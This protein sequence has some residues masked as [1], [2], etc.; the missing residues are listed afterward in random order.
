MPPVSEKQR[1]AMH[2]AAHGKST[3]GIPSSVGREFAESDPGGKLPAAKDLAPR[4]WSLLRRLFGEWIDEEQGEPEHAGDAETVHD[5]K[6]GQFTSGSGSKSSE[7]SSE[8]FSSTNHGTNKEKAVSHVKF[9]RTLNH[10]N[11]KATKNTKGEYVVAH[12]FPP[13][14]EAEINKRSRFDPDGGSNDPSRHVNQLRNRRITGD[15][16]PTLATAPNS[17]LPAG[18]TTKTPKGRAASILFA[19]PG[20]KALFLRRSADEENYPDTWALPGGKADEDEEFG[21]CAARE[22]GEETGR[23]CAADMLHEVDRKRTPYGWDHVTFISPVDEEFEPTLNNEHSEHVWSPWDDPPT[24]LHPGV[25]QTLASLAERRAAEEDGA[26]DMN[27]KRVQGGTEPTVSLTELLPLGTKQL[28]SPESPSQGKDMAPA[29]WSML[30]RLFGEWLAE[31]E[32]EPEHAAEDVDLKRDEAGKFATS[33]SGGNS[34]KGEQ[35]NSRREHQESQVL[36]G[37]MAKFHHGRG[38]HEHAAAH[39]YASETHGKAAEVNRWGNKSGE[40]TVSSSQAARESSIHANHKSGY[41]EG[42][43]LGRD[44]IPADCN[45]AHDSVYR[46]KSCAADGTWAYDADLL[47]ATARRARL[48]GRS[49]IA[50][51]AEAIAA[52]EFGAADMAMDWRGTAFL[53]DSSETAADALVSLAFDRESTRTYDPDGRLHVQ[54]AHIS[55]ANVCSYLGREIPDYEQLGLDPDKKYMLYRDPEELSAATDTFNNLPILSEHKP[56]SADE[57][58]HDLVIGSTGTDA[59]FDGTHLDNSLAF[60]PRDAIDDIESNNK[61]QLS[62]AYRYR[63]DMTPGA[64]DSGEKYDGVMRDIVGNHVALV[65]EGRAGPDVVVGDEANPGLD[66]HRGG[67]TMKLRMTPRGLVTAGAIGAYLRPRLAADSRIPVGRLVRDLT[68]QNFKARMPSVAAAIRAA[69]KGRLAADADL[70]D[71]DEFLDAIQGEKLEEDAAPE[72]V[73]TNTGATGEG[74]DDEPPEMLAKIR[75]FLK[76]H[77]DD[78][79]LAQFDEM[80]GEESHVV[81]KEPEEVDEDPDKKM[82]GDEPADFPGKPK[83]VTKE[84]MDAAISKA[85][86]TATARHAAVATAQNAVRP[87]VGSELTIAC[88]S[89]DAVY[90]RALDSLGVSHEGIGETAALQRILELT[91]KP[92]ATPVRF[93]QDAASEAGFSKRYPSAARIEQI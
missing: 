19:A 38:E 75:E 73:L 28:E 80:V 6:N 2:A 49:D 25:S 32:A 82:V 68:R 74:S 81:A 34:L 87:W 86:A 39:S 53:V 84:A 17:G 91:P 36:H 79:A 35:A 78:E 12:G 41:G 24:P 93:A 92:G 67:R 10:T 59:E 62:C 22:A 14:T 23:D 71:L 52:R 89:A 88:D 3:L 18:I 29:K 70:E 46:V 55:K 1:A 21:D 60:W 11:A 43:A 15:D 90:R 20:G 26:E 76:D 8:R 64:T 51:R 77:L 47:Q 61:K 69:A 40:S 63:A 58:D 65:H 45:L 54:R 56:V 9:L 48:R 4:K 85:V 72:D 50:R 37:K 83:L 13:A 33:A 57:H 44:N 7:F 30:R 42:F 31:E 27:F 16:L 66:R 5:P